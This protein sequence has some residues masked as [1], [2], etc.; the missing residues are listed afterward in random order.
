M[1]L[2]ADKGKDHDMPVLT[3]IFRLTGLAGAFIIIASQQT[4]AA[5]LNE[6][7]E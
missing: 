4:R 5:N 1:A 3:G 2:F 6:D 7:C